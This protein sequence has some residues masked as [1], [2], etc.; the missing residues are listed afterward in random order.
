MM[1]I[2]RRMSIPG[3]INMGLII[4]CGLPYCVCLIKGNGICE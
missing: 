2:R 1:L 3:V 4:V